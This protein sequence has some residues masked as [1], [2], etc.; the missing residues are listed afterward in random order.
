[1]L[2][3]LFNKQ[4]RKKKILFALVCRMLCLPGFHPQLLGE[5]LPPTPICEVPEGSHLQTFDKAT[6]RKYQIGAPWQSIAGSMAG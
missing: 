4:V 6:F 1:M 5:K 2:R 3:F